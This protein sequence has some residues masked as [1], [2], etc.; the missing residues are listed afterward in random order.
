MNQDKNELL[1]NAH[2]RVVNIGFGLEPMGNLEDYFAQKLMI[3][4]TAAD[5]KYTSLAGLRKLIQ[6]GQEQSVGMDKRLSRSEVYRTFS[7]DENVAIIVEDITA[8]FTINAETMQFDVRSSAIFE[9]KNRQW[10]VIHWHASK[11]E[12]VESEVDTFGIDE[13]KQK[14]DALEKIVAE[15]TADLVEKN[16][17]LEIESSLERVRSVAMGMRK[18]DDLLSIAESLYNELRVLGFPD[19]RNAMIHRY[20]DEKNEFLDYDFSDFSGGQIARIPYSGNPVIERFIQDIR[21]TN[22]SFTEIIITDKQL[23]DWKQLRKS[24][25][26]IDDT[27]LNEASVVYYYN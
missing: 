23:D 15:R 18:P 24:N 13:W 17:E 26:E 6:N 5:E 21:K 14:A 12:S 16:R 8:F 27:R 7:A 19:L 1:T 4:G 3:I 10:K 9:F 25:G 20:F 22:E 11:P 2:N